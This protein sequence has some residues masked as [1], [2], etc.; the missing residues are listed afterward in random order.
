MDFIVP[1]QPEDLMDEDKAP[2]GRAVDLKDLAEQSK[3]DVSE[4]AEGA[5]RQHTA[6]TQH[7]Q[8]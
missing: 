6:V 4:Y 8:P 1:A 7:E 3:E 5:C 2:G